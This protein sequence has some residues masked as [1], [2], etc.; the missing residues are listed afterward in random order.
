MNPDY[1]PKRWWV[2]DDYWE[3]YTKQETKRDVYTTS[4]K[5]DWLAD[6]YDAYIHNIEKESGVYD[7]EDK[8]NDYIHQTKEQ[9][10]PDRVWRSRRFKEGQ[11]VQASFGHHAYYDR[12]GDVAIIIQSDMDMHGRATTPTSVRVMWPDGDIED[13]SED[14]LKMI[15]DNNV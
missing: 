13:V 4:M 15:D 12:K 3:E 8:L 1:M 2:D 11:L 14:D 9:S 7:V 5:R 6:A 10:D